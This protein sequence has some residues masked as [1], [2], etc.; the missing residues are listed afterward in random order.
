MSQEQ[1][2]NIVCQRLLCWLDFPLRIIEAFTNTK[3]QLVIVLM[4]VNDYLILDQQLFIHTIDVR[5]CIAIMSIMAM[6][7][8][9]TVFPPRPPPYNSLGTAVGPGAAV[10]QHVASS[11]IENRSFYQTH[12]CFPCINVMNCLVLTRFLVDT[13]L[14]S[15]VTVLLTSL[16]CVYCGTHFMSDTF[17]G[18]LFGSLVVSGLDRV[19]WYFQ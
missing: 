1:I 19:L 18:Y 8:V 2:I 14:V 9:A 15:S 17:F 4:Y 11:T 6:P 3:T 5:K 12:H 10:G 16:S 7:L 13:P